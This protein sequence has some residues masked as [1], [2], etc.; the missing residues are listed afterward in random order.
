MAGWLE[1]EDRT[2]ALRRVLEEEVPP[3]GEPFPCPYLPDRI[4]RNITIQAGSLPP[5]VY[6]AFMDLNFRRMGGLFYR[7]DCPGCAEC[8][9]LRVPVAEFRPSRAQRRCQAANADLNV[10]VGEPRLDAERERLYADYLEARHDGQMQGSPAEL[11]DFLYTSNVE[12]IEVVCRLA[13]RIV[14]VGIA[15]VEPLAL[16]AVYCYFAPDLKIRS[17]GVFNVLSLLEECR[18]RDLSHLYLGYYVAGSPRMSYKASFRPCEQLG[19]GGWT[20]ARPRVNAPRSGKHVT[21][22]RGGSSRS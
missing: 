8:R 2:R 19:P 20:L 9:M 1:H 11:R 18:R 15:D 13:G 21:R 22:V 3:P 14:A 6:H 7:P 12:T 4:S 16:S 10:A 5:G 17:L